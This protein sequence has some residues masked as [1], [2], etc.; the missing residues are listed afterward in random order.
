MTETPNPRFYDY[1]TPIT[2]SKNDSYDYK[3]TGP[4]REAPVYD[5]HGRLIGEIWTDGRQAAG[6]TLIDDP[7]P[8]MGYVGGSMDRILARAYKAGIPASEL[9]NPALYA[10]DFELRV[11]P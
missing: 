11:A 7:E 5:R 2:V 1:V 10:P 9:L 8:D 3:A 4:V 6:F